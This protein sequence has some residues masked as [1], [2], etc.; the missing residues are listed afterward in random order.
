M[1]SAPDPGLRRVCVHAGTAVVDLALPAAVP[2]ANLIPSIIDILDDCGVDR[3]GDRPG[4]PYRLAAPGVPA[5]RAST[6]LAQNDIR[7][8]AVLILSQARADPPAPRYDDVAEAVAATLGVRARP[9]TRR[10]SRLT[11]AVTAGF[12][13]GVGGLVLVRN[14]LGDNAT[15]EVGTA[16]GVAGLAAVLGL[17]IA[18]RAAR[19][20]ITG[21]TL[22]LLATAFA[23]LA[24]FTAVP[25]TPGAPNV[26]LAAMG[27]AVAS[28][29]A[30]RLTN[31]DVVALTAV[32]VFAMIAAGAAFADVLTAAPVRTVAA[33][34][35]LVSLG[36]LGIA[37]RVSI[38]LARLS[39]HRPDDA[40]LGD[41]AMRADAWLASLLA[42]FSSSAAV[43]AIVTAAAAPGADTEAFA[44]VTAALLLLRARSADGTTTLVLV[45]SGIA[46]VGTTFAIASAA[47]PDRAAWITAATAMMAAAA[48]CLGFLAPAMSPVQHRI[49]ELSEYLAFLAMAPLACWICGFYGAVRALNPA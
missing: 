39:P 43:A 36:L 24:G 25:G 30:I 44:F 8:G 5:L 7:D 32:A 35:A 37:G 28:V 2:I 19:D 16:A 33:L 6:T 23:A 14:A 20:P 26:L 17:L 46:T 12:L 31:R 34:S 22:S 29:L 38:A 49:V 11:G 42:A 4:R 48:L 40:H 13:T 9:W 47:A 27:A 21:L 45:V 3:S 15:R 1:L 18:R 10:A 41:K